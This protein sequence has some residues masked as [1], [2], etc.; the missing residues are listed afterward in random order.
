LQ[1]E[2]QV[3]ANTQAAKQQALRDSGTW[4]PA[5]AEVN[6]AL[7]RTHEFFDPRDV[8]Q[9]KYEMLRRVERDGLS[10]TQAARSFGFS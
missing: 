9:V 2:E 10:V 4:N 7:F 8:V 3:I 5:A 1:S 6:D